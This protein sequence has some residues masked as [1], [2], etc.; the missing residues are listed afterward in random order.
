MNA[1]ELLAFERTRPR[2]DGTKE[3]AIRAEFGI[4]PARYYIFLTRAA[5]SLEGLAADPITAR[6]VRAAGERRRERTA[7]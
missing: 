1:A 6:R 7:A 4:T 2:H 5:G 3:E